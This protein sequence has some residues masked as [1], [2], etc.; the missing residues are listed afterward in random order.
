MPAYFT[1]TQERQ[2]KAIEKRCVLR[3]CR[4]KSRC[5]VACTGIGTKKLRTECLRACGK[6]AKCTAVCK[7]TAARIVNAARG[8]RRRRR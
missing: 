7:S 8:R 6:K 5:R 4:S 3:R 1:K 2:Y